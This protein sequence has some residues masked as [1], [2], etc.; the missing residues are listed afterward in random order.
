MAEVVFDN[1]PEEVVHAV[2]EFWH[3]KEGDHVEE[4][5]DL[6]DL[7]GDGNMTCIIT[8]PVTGILSARFYR[9]EDEVE[10]G[11]ILA[12]IE[13]DIEV[14]EEEIDLEVLADDEDVYEEEVT[15]EEE[16][17]EDLEEIEEDE[18]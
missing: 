12:E 10:I 7:K 4:G 8:A 17:E 14:L 13:E 15:V 16:E 5:E 6:V 1:V 2:V 9:E 18:F 3:F 11:E